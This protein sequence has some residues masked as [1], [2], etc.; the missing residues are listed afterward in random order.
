MPD[1][2]FQL[3]QYTQIL[4]YTDRSPLLFLPSS[5]PNI[6][7]LIS[8]KQRLQKYHYLPVLAWITR[9]N[10]RFY[11]D[12]AYYSAIPDII[13]TGHICENQS[14]IHCNILKVFIILPSFGHPNWFYAIPLKLSNVSFKSILTLDKKRDNELFQG[15]V[16]E[17]VTSRILNLP[18]QIT[19]FFG[20]KN[21]SKAC[22]KEFFPCETKISR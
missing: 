2:L 18:H 20:K 7:M 17:P 15:T 22:F 21:S 3:G 10:V 5:N 6:N 8:F 13:I 16:S 14:S 19:C 4:R 11:A 9:R 12:S 1:K